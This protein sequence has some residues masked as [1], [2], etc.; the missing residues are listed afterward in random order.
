MET[1]KCIVIFCLLISIVFIIYF[2]NNYNKESF[3][4][5]DSLEIS[6]ACFNNCQNLNNNSTL[7]LICNC[8]KCCE[9][10]ILKSNFCNSMN[11]LLNNFIC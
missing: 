8:K 7:A 6:D 11:P 2:I 3:Q 10:N 5:I 1:K 4:E 9:K